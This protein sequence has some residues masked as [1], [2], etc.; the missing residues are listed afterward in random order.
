MGKSRGNSFV[1]ALDGP[2]ASGKGTLGELIAREYGFAYLD[3]GSLYRGVAWLVLN[4]GGDPGDED[5]AADAAE[6]FTLQSIEGADIRT[7]E[8]GAAASKVAAM[9]RVRKALLDFQRRFASNPPGGKRGAVLDG[10]DIGT[11]VCPDATVKFFVIA[12]PDVRANRRWLEL[13]PQKPHLTEKEVF[14]DLAE[15]DARDAARTDAPMVQADDAELLDTTH[16][17]IEAAFAAAR[18]VIDGVLQRCEG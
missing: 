14:D 16:L 4:E 6:R 15:R 9:P 11:V 10:R 17:T 18:R 12:S 1:I 7:R 2:A 5:E 13:L 3:T 8:V